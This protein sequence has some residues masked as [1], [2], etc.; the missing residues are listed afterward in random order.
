MSHAF[1]ME[2]SYDYRL[3]AISLV[4]AFLVSYTAIDFET[5]PGEGTT[6]IICLPHIGKTSIE[7]PVCA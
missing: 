3:V 2:G 1:V 4:I 6:F 7:E 5:L